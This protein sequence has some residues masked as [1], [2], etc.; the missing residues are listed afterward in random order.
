MDFDQ[1]VT[2]FLS[3]KD[4]ECCYFGSDL[5]RDLRVVYIVFRG[6]VIALFNDGWHKQL[7][8]VVLLKAALHLFHY[9]ETITSVKA[10]FTLA[11]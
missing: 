10:W 3:K 7:L 9:H 1:N 8:L 2:E 11:T 5:P 4:L 6:I